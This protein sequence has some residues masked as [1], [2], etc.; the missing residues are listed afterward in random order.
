M[1]LL[2]HEMLVSIDPGAHRLIV[3][4]TVTWSDPAAVF[5]AP[6]SIRFQIHAGLSPVCTTKGAVLTRRSGSPEA[7]ASKRQG[8]DRG[9]SDRVPVEE[10]ELLLPPETQSA[11]LHYEGTIEHAPVAPVTESARS[12]SDTPGTI[13]PEGVFLSP[14]VRWY[15]WLGDHLVSFSMDVTLPAGW[16]AV[17]QGAR[18]RPEATKP[19]EAAASGSQSGTPPAVSRVTWAEDRPQ[20]G[21]TLAA[22][23][24]TEYTRPA[25]STTAMVFLRT[26]DSDLANRYLDAT[27]KYLDTYSKMIGPYPYAKFALVEN[28]WESGLGLPSYTLLGPTVLRLPFIIDTSYPHE[29]LHSWWGNSVFVAEASG[30]W[31]EGLTAYQADYRLKEERSEGAGYRRD[32]LQ[33]YADFVSQSKDF[34]LTEFRERESPAT[35]AVGYGKA[36]MLFHML[37]RAYGDDAWL[38]ALRRFYEANRFRKASWSDLATAFPADAPSPDHLSAKEMIAEWTSRAG[39]PRL[40]VEGVV[41]HA[42]EG[43]G[44]EWTIEGTLTQIQSEAPWRADVPVVVSLL[45]S[46]A[47]A[48]HTV[49]FDGTRRSAPIRIAIGTQP[50]TVEIDPD[51]DLFRRIEREEIPPALSLAFGADTALVVLPSSEPA[52]IQQGYRAVAEGWA[53]GK[54]STLKIALDSEIESLPDDRTVWIFGWRNRFLSSVAGPLAAYEARIQ[55]GALRIGN[56]STA[57]AKH[58]AAL[59]VPL[60]GHPDLALGWVAADTAAALPG[61][62][63]KLPH[64][65]KYSYLIFEGDEPT[66]TTKGNWPVVGSPL[67]IELRSDGRPARASRP[68]AQESAAAVQRDMSQPDRMVA[69]A[70]AVSGP[71]ARV[72]PDW[73]STD[74]MM[75]TV[76]GLSAPDLEGRGFGSRG[77]DTAAERIA[78]AF[79]EAGLHP[80]GDSEGSWFQKWKATGGDPAREVE[81]KNVVGILPGSSAAKDGPVVVIGAHY[82]HLGRGWPDAKAGNAGKIHPGADDNASGV[83]VLLELARAMARQRSMPAAASQDSPALVPAGA[84]P[85]T[86]VFVAF[87]GEEAGL[88]GSKRFLSAPEFAPSNC[89]AMIN[90]DTVGRLGSGRLLVL[91]AGSAPEW[92]TI[93]QAIRT[94][95]PLEIAP[96]DPG[97]SDQKTFIDAGVPAVQFFTGPHADY[98]TAGDTPDKIDA[99]G[100]KL[101][102]LAAWELVGVLAPQGTALHATNPAPSAASGSPPAPGS[103]TAPG[104]GGAGSGATRRVTLGTVPDFAYEGAGVRLSG[105]VPGSPAEKAGLTAGDIIVKLGETPITDLRAF[106]DALKPLRP[107]DRVQVVFTRDGK[108]RSIQTEVVGR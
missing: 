102:T 48:L 92:G 74:R 49:H 30:N 94:G 5:L 20:D 34:P 45:H 106:S 39:A 12:F 77:L 53:R 63:R 91:G 93:L 10:Y 7:Y 65:A 6:G 54:E 104:S 71:A 16:D 11:V 70:G 47:G 41:A 40:C 18:T 33:K 26:P 13:G 55:D 88:L 21:I 100:L 73:I 98:H 76:R 60:P 90:F 62:G 17:A 68:C 103:G 61:L 52:E 82:D 44:S 37:R 89:G 64:Y 3:T 81:L 78:S 22:A 36:M 50:A 29:I 80:G 43:S 56:D 27:V 72:Q 28:F 66:N 97:G 83:A 96:G 67:T 19:A 84:A 32:A 14:G 57:R 95:A 69:A 46:K 79:R 59:V 99:T 75:E 108:E 8:V 2:R 1:A 101:V 31:C 58:S 25:G 107:G 42:P 86:L 9:L 38:A 35:E 23:R 24:F 4:D 51:F 15:P 85:R 105:V 87:S